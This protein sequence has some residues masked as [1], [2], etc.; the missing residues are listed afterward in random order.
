MGRNSN[1]VKIFICYGFQVCGPMIFSLEWG[2]ILQVIHT[3]FRNIMLELV[4]M[5]VVCFVCL[6]SDM[7]TRTGSFLAN[8][9]CD[10]V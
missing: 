1:E 7:L 9:T 10:K 6:L 8:Y 4:I 3:W 5:G 2:T